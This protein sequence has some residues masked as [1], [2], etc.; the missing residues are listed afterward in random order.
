ML[1]PRA[2]ALTLYVAR[3]RRDPAWHDLLRPLRASPIARGVDVAECHGRHPDM[4]T[5]LWDAHAH[6]PRRR[7]ARHQALER[8]PGPRG[9]GAPP[10]RLRRRPGARAAAPPARRRC[11]PPGGGGAA[12][13]AGGDDEAPPAE[14]WGLADE[15]ATRRLPL[16]AQG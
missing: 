8:I 7:V 5:W 6:R 15:E 13:A 11:R 1:D 4:P 10:R 16:G 9:R 12:P 2:A 3:D 14:F